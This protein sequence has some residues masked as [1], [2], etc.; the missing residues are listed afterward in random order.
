MKTIR[1]EHRSPI[2]AP[3]DAVWNFHMDPAALEQLSP[4]WT[5][6]RIID[7]GAGVTDGSLVKAEVGF[8]PFRQQWHALHSG[9]KANR[10]FTDMAVQSPFQYWVHQHSMIPVSSRRSELK[11]VIWIVPPRW[12]PTSIA[13]PLIKAGLRFLFAWRHR[14]TRRAVEPAASSRQSTLDP[15]AQN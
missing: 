9:V 1:F 11:D 7:P 5:G 6:L 15:C 10:G 8:G 13:R 4:K 14:Q 12:I 2:N 3:A